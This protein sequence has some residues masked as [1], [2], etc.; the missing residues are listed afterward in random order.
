MRVPSDFAGKLQ[1]RSGLA[2]LQ[3]ELAGETAASLGRAGREVE[4]SLERLRAFD[5]EAPAAGDRRELVQAAAR[6]VWAYWV[7]REAC[8]LVDHRQVIREQRI[9]REVLNRVGLL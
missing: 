6:A 3:A 1:A 8:G 7:Q 5:A 4:A 2:A 9:P